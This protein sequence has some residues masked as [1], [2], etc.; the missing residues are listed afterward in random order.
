MKLA[1]N[2]LV[3]ISMA[4]MTEALV[5]G[6]QAGLDWHTMLDVFSDSAVSSPLLKY[7]SVTLAERDFEPAFTTAL[8]AKD[9][10]LMLAAARE[11]GAVTPLTA[12]T[13]QLL[14]ATVGSG[15][16]SADFSATALLYERLIAGPDT[17]TTKGI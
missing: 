5:F 10:Q 2:A 14:L 4:G 13:E 7:K 1:L 3:A 12:A 17:T 16:G 6:V 9:M 15:W 8:L 11:H